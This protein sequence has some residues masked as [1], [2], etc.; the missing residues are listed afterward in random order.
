MRWYETG[1]PGPAEVLRVA[2]FQGVVCGADGCE[3]QAERRAESTAYC[4]LHFDRWKSNGDPLVVQVR[5]R[6]RCSIE[7]CD[8]NV[9]AWGWCQNHLKRWQRWGDPLV[10]GRGGRRCMVC[11]H[12]ER[13]AIDLALLSGEV[14]REVGERYG[15]GSSVPWH[16]LNCLGLIRGDGPHCQFCVH[17]DRDLF[18]QEILDGATV[19][20]TARRW[21][22]SD[23][24]LANHMRP[25][26]ATKSMRLAA[27]RLDAVR[28]Y[29]GS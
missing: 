2:S 17:P 4:R 15:L 19:A 18:E 3:L 9:K 26:H 7:G 21:G 8:R 13:T 24:S 16:S 28:R 20:A 10:V 1:D 29:V 12:P 27:S 22:F 6:A 11:H 5:E 23:R 25:G 14:Q